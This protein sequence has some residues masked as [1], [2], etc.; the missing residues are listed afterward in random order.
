MMTRADCWG[1]DVQ[2]VGQVVQ[3]WVGGHQVLRESFD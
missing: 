2:A 1:V 3:K